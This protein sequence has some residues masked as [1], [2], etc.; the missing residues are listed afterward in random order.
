MPE[1]SND[2]QKAKENKRALGNR[3]ETAAVSFLER[4]GC[5]IIQRNFRSRSGEIDII[6]FDSD[7]ETLC[8]GEVKYRNNLNSG[9]PEEAVNRKKQ[10]IICR[11]SDVYRGKHGLDE[12]LSYRYDVI[13]ITPDGINWHKNAFEYIR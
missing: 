9:Y 8:F 12:S 4:E 5:S 6:Y 3:E 10:R 7:G 11:V 1:R 2:T 13:A